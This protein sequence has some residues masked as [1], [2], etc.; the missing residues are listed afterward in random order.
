LIPSAY[1]T[2]PAHQ[3]FED[4]E[5]TLSRARLST[6]QA[7]LL[8]SLLERA[9]REQEQLSRETVAQA[10]SKFPG[11]SALESVLPE[12]APGLA[13]SLGMLLTLLTPLATST[14][15]GSGLRP[16]VEQGPAFTAADANKTGQ[17]R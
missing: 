8:V 11:L 7:Q 4:L 17:V 6:P 16:A 10:L 14:G 3:A 1:Y 2:A 5:R 12:H 9:L 13:R 15:N